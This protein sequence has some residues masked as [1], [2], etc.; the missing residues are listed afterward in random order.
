MKSH[1]KIHILI[2]IYLEGE[3]VKGQSENCH[4]IAELY[5][6]AKIK[7][8]ALSHR[9]K[10]RCRKEDMEFLITEDEIAE[11]L[12]NLHEVQVAKEY[13]APDFKEINAE[14]EEVKGRRQKEMKALK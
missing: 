7:T 8:N 14:W 4:S 5:I 6:A 9:S 2:Y 13:F 1:M 12:N 11:K 3:K 10:K